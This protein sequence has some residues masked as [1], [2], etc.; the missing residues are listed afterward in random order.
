[1]LDDGGVERDGV[2]GR[3]SFGVG[4]GVWDAGLLWW[5]TGC[6]QS[7]LCVRWL[8]IAWAMR[9]EVYVDIVGVG[10]DSR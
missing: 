6:W 8:I 3:R 9:S 5:K 7:V 10:L 2:G 4:V 1:L